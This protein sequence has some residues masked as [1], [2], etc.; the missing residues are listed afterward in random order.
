MKESNNKATFFAVA[1]LVHRSPELFQR[2]VDEGHE[3]ASHSYS[4]KMLNK[5]SREEFEK[6]FEKSM[7]IFS[8]ITDHKISGFRAPSW[9]VN[10]ENKTYVID[11][12]N[13]HGFLYDSSIFPFKTFLYGDNNA[14]HYPYVINSD[15]SPPLYEVPP[16]I[17]KFNRIRIPFSGGFYFRVLP[18]VFIK[19]SIKKTN[20]MGHPAV[21][22]LHAYDMDPGQPKNIKGFTNRM[23]QYTNLKS[24]KGKLQKLLH[25]F[26]F[27]RMDEYVKELCQ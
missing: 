21:I 22:Y 6:D 25:D 12:L 4:H 26:K 11:I 7:D 13:K 2:I 19:N 15:N 1:S 16:S 5:Q 3:L 18:Y 17:L 14:P 23:I 24:C 10:E 9:S 8:S 20:K 27:G